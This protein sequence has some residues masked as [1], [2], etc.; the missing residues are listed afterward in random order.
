MF[1]DVR[2]GLRLYSRHRGLALAAVASLAL[3]IGANTAIFSVLNAV[4]LQPLPF[5][6]PERLVI[7]WETADKSPTRWVAPANYLDWRREA[8]SFAS[9][10]AFDGFSV[11]FTGRNEPE[12]LRAAG[13]S[14]EFFATLGTR[15]ALGRTLLASD[16]EPD[17]PPVAVLTHGLW[18]RLFGASPEAIGQTLTLDNRAH[19]IVGVLPQDWTMPMTADVEIWM[20]GDRGIPRSFPFPGDIRAVRDSHILYVVGRLRPGVSRDAAQAELSSI[21]T[22][23]A[24]TYPNTNTGLGVNVVPL[25]EQVVG[26]VRPLVMLLQAAVAIMLLIGCV[27]VA[28]LLLGQAASRQMELATRLALGAQRGRLVRQLLAE[29]L[30]LAVPGGMLGLL[31]AA[32]GLGA[33]VAMAPSELP[34]LDEIRL[35]AT[36]LAFTLGVTLTTALAFGLGP[37]LR[38]SQV[39]A[40][41]TLQ[42]SVRVAGGQSV[43]RWHRVMT[44]AELALAQVLL[45]GAGL[46]FASFVASQR[47]ELGFVPDDRIAA[48]L[49]LAPDPYLRPLPGQAPS[50]FRV[51]VGPKRRL[52]E[53]VLDRLRHTTGVR[54]AAASFTAPLAG[55][56]NRGLSIEG[57]PEPPPGLEPNADFQIVTVDY[58]RALGLTLIKGR[59][60][61]ERDRADAP[62]VVIINQALSDRYF[63]GRD[64]IG[65]VILF[66][67]RAR[68]EVVGIVAD[69]RYRSVEQPADPTFYVPF[70][71]NEERWPFLS[72]TAWVDGDPASLAP[73][74]RE[75]V[76]SI[77][78]N[79]PIARIRTYDEILRGALAPR[80]F[81][82]LL[83][84]MF[85]ATALLLAIVGTYGV[86]AYSVSTRTREIGVRSALGA[87]PRELVRL[88]V[89]EG[90]WLVLVAVVIG[91]AAGLLLTDFLGGLLY[92]V[93]PRD[94]FT[95]VVV[96]VT[97]A[98][99][100][101]AATLIPARRATRIQPVSALR[102]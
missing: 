9:L 72:F 40:N 74:I 77:D 4:V 82:T 70:E 90:V 35:D 26:R 28:N 51:D 63:A 84:A 22:R 97:L 8:R 55:A 68:H 56:P 96:S 59:A 64:P 86:M 49:T 25:H 95:F 75:A 85:A 1:N 73:T 98:V 58:F 44:V 18:Q 93:A 52:V 32:W 89:A 43:R 6:D 61:D 88:V 100:A 79:Q 19:I 20:S 91:V 50:D 94:P 24:A 53:G 76:R 10:A 13:A 47:V 81:N 38:S 17:A 29:T 102:E 12:R 65:R 62:P 57:D 78:P 11:N 39:S 34:R 99:V 36:V 31:V 30:V 48:D 46:L 101:I 83:V 66:G 69:A 15:A 2:L 60:F 3:G 16:D 27:N 41:P 37:A 71:Q 14:G 23:L 80:R 92:G 45:V 7:A 54:A 33:L 21:M 5:Q 42:A 67:G 87:G